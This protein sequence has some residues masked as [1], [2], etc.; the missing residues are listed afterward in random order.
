MTA[1]GRPVSRVEGLDKVTG[2]AVYTAD[3]VVP[4]IAHAVLVQSTIPHGRVLAESLLAA[5][6]LASAAPG[7]LR[8]I[9]PLNCP[10]LK[11]PPREM[12]DDLPLERR[13]PLADLTVQHVGQHIA[14]VVA[15]T[16]ENATYGAS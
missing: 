14:V 4:N 8:V 7:V 11:P 2:A 16:L 13:P 15:D 5:T 12:S 6:R 1:V 9:T 10:P 3:V